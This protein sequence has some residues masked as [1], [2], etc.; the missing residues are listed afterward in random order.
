MSF[1]P[2]GDEE[3]VDEFEAEMEAELERRAQ[4]AERESGLGGVASTSGGVAGARTSSKKEDKYDRVYFDSDEEDGGEGGDRKVK[5]DDELFYD[6]DED[7]RNQK[8]VDDMRQ[9]YVSQNSKR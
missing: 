1:P 3:D 7:D 6:P 2:G 5:N 8:W 4:D 9:K